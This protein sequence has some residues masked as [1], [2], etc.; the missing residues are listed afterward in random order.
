METIYENNPYEH[1]RGNY[2]FKVLFGIFPAS[3]PDNLLIN[4][5]RIYSRPVYVI[6]M[7][8]SEG[9]RSV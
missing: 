2:I 5:A 9:V 7:I 4:T 3:T 8:Q 6:D 1:F